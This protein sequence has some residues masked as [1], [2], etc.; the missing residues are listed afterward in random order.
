MLGAVACGGGGGGSAGEDGGVDVP[1]GGGIVDMCGDVR[2]SHRVYYGTENPTY[3]PLAPGQVWAVGTWNGC[4]GTLIAPRWVLT[5]D[6]CQLSAGDE[7]CIGEAAASPNV[8]MSTVRVVSNPATDMTLAELAVDA[9]AQLPGVQPVPIMTEL[10]DATWV[11]RMAEAAGYGQQEDGGFGEREFTAEPIDELSGH[12]MTIN[13]MGMRGVCFGDSGGPVFVI[14]SDG[15]VRTAGDLSNGDGNCVGR[16][17]FARTD[18]NVDWIES[19]T[20]PTVVEGAMCGNVDVAGRCSG[21]LAMWCGDDGLLQTEACTGACGWDESIGGYRCIDGPDPCGGVDG[22]GACDGDVARWCE[23]GSPKSRDCNTCGLVC[24]MVAGV[25][26][27][28]IDDPCM[29][30]DYLGRCNGNVAEWCDGGQ[31]QSRDCS[32]TGETCEYINDEV[33][34]YCN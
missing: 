30:L 25:G 15:T 8:C 10:M 34:W 11:G 5:A 1:D 4:S 24:D 19:Y 29:G 27:D 26:A 7:F 2:A 22:Y 3:V 21:G 28:C 16:D 33:G 6:H 17:N 20:G 31:L 9:T 13:G 23:A 12:F 18:T 32:E 14:A